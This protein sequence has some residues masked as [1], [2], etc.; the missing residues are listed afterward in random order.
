MTTNKTPGQISTGQ[1]GFKTIRLKLRKKTVVRFLRG[2]PQ[3][4]LAGPR[5]WPRS[6]GFVSCLRVEF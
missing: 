3:I 2:Q 6:L 1:R 4:P 5:S